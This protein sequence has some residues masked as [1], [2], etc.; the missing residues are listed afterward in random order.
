[1]TAKITPDDI[2]RIK[3]N[4]KR[5]LENL[6]LKYSGI[7]DSMDKAMADSFSGFQHS[8]FK[9]Y[10]DS[11]Y[12]ETT[13]NN[14]EDSFNTNIILVD[15]RQGSF[16]GT[17]QLQHPDIGQ[18]NDGYPYIVNVAVNPDYREQGIGGRLLREIENISREKKYPEVRLTIHFQHLDEFY[19]EN[20]FQKITDGNQGTSPSPSRET[21]WFYSKKITAGGKI[22]SRKIQNTSRTRTRNTTTKNR[23]TTKNNK[24][25]KKNKLRRKQLR[26]KRHHS[27]KHSKHYKHSK[28]IHT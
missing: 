24:T 25:T 4:S 6:Y 18:G 22:K 8:S 9:Q 5:D 28:L 14:P 13:N 20:G 15:K 11:T 26:R 3:I 7:A 16:I 17:A 21:P 1:M 27:R 2:E 23:I 12:D 19:R 10:L